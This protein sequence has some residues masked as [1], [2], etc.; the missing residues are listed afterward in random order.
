[1]VLILK[2]RLQKSWMGTATSSDEDKKICVVS[3][4]NRPFEH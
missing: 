2:I 3:N 1:M 4:Y